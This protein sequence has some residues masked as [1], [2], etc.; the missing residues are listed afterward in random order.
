MSNSDSNAILS[1]LYKTAERQRKTLEDT[2]AQID[3]LEAMID[4]L[5]KTPKATPAK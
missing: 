5:R 1:R 2:Q 3:E 4:Q